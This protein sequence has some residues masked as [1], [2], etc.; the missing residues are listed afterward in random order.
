[1]ETST[2]LVPVKQRRGKKEG[3][4]GAVHFSDPTDKTRYMLL[5]MAQS[6]HDHEAGSAKAALKRKLGFGV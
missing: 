5:I 4:G 1:M 3:W 6:P 2:A